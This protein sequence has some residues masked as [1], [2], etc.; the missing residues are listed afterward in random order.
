MNLEEWLIVLNE[1]I[2]NHQEQTNN[3][4]LEKSLTECHFSEKIK[5]EIARNPAAKHYHISEK[6]QEELTQNAKTEII[7]SSSSQLED[8]SLSYNP[9]TTPEQEKKGGE[10]SRKLG[11]RINTLP[12]T[13]RNLIEYAKSY[14]FEKA[15]G[16]F[17]IEITWVP[18]EFL[19]EKILEGP[20]AN[21]FRA[22]LSQLLLHPEMR[23]GTNCV[24]NKL[25]VKCTDRTVNISAETYDFSHN[26]T[27]GV[28]DGHMKELA[29]ILKPQKAILEI[30][31]KRMTLLDEELSQVFLGQ[32]MV[33]NLP[34]IP[35]K[36]QKIVDNIVNYTAMEAGVAL[37]EEMETIIKKEIPYNFVSFF[38]RLLHLHLFDSRKNQKTKITSLR[39]TYSS[40][41][42]SEPKRLSDL[43]KIVEKLMTITPSEVLYD[44]PFITYT[45]AKN[46]LEKEINFIG[47]VFEDYETF[48]HNEDNQSLKNYQ[49]KRI[50]KY[51]DYFLPTESILRHIIDDYFIGT[52]EDDKKVRIRPRPGLTDS[53]SRKHLQE[54][55]YVPSQSFTVRQ[56]DGY[57]YFDEANYCLDVLHWF[58]RLYEQNSEKMIEK[59]REYFINKKP[60]LEISSSFSGDLSLLKTL[61]LPNRG[62]IKTFRI[63][64]RKYHQGNLSYS[65]EENKEC[66]GF[67]VSLSNSFLVPLQAYMCKE[68][69]IKFIE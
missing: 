13:F 51:N 24:T 49:Q 38:E 18:E 40:F 50:E 10:Y 30:E 45:E 27:R 12:L 60:R 42:N 31:H 69:G 32:Q 2:D 59:T 46:I 20:L 9:F 53:Y 65:F 64:P 62:K 25:M 23:D 66:L 33:K 21:N 61:I 3:D 54:L 26:N 63:S 41:F 29:D 1:R 67:F 36:Y 57:E 28:F 16:Q 5:E 68:L 47:K 14:S 6:I 22:D 19:Q 11:F 55:G 7:L 39:K 44:Y 48:E 15:Q 43:Q 37:P 52:N 34:K 8:F 17:Y 35:L 4:N 56:D 58:K